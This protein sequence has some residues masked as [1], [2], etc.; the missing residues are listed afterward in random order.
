MALVPDLYCCI[1][2]ARI[3]PNSFIFGQCSTLC[4]FSPSPLEA[5]IALIF[6]LI[7]IRGRAFMFG[8][9]PTYSIYVFY[10][11]ARQFAWDVPQ[12]VLVIGFLVATLSGFYNAIKLYRRR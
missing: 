6:L 2:C 1:R 11:L 8:L 3:L 4:N 7:A 5:I 9:M 12:P 10:D